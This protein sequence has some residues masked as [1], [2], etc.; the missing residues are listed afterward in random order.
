[1]PG[2]YVITE[3]SREGWYHTTPMSVT[4]WIASY[5]GVSQV[6]FG[7]VPMNAICGVKFFDKDMDGVM[8]AGEP[9][10]GD[11]TITLEKE[12]SAGVW[13]PWMTTVTDPAGAYCFKWLLP[14]N[15]RVNE[16]LQSGW[17]A[18]SALPIEIVIP[19]YTVSHQLLPGR[20]TQD[21]GNVMYGSISGYKF[22]DLIGPNGEYPNGL[23]DPS[24]YGIGNWEIKLEGRQVNKVLVQ[25][26]VYT[27]NVGPLGDIGKYLFADLLPGVY[28]V[29]ETELA[30]W[31]PT[32][33]CVA[34]LYLSAYP[35]WPVNL[36]QN[37]GNMHPADPEMNFVLKAGVNMWSSP[38]QMTSSM[39]AS[40]LAAI[41]GSSCLKVSRWNTTT[42]NWQHFIPGFTPVGSSKDFRLANGEGYLVT[43]KVYTAFTLSGDLVTGS[44]VKV[45]TGANLVGFDT[46]KPMRASD[47]AKLFTL[48][49][50]G[51]ILK[52]STLSESGQ[53]QHY[54]PGFTPAGSA[55]DYTVTQGHSYLVFTTSG[56]M[57][58]FPA[59]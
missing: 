15:Y 24:E 21:I 22:E 55:K 58:T 32:T 3:E 59:A 14:G 36:V 34:K 50:G 33:T 17:F 47:F 38:L 2:V 43:S 18:T 4:L 35:F 16:V 6:K 56:G 45:S 40:E 44:Q 29:N 10:L 53:W 28:W 52:I 54:I 42:A 57:I 1:L 26:T 12:T 31:V 30:N 37:F 25:R 27:V 19:A 5:H 9:G 49:D 23:M 46:L 48:D 11:W 20:I 51:K 39:R 7:N 13:T 8:D 41:I